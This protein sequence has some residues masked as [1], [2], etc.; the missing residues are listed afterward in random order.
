MTFD[1][2]LRTLHIKSYKKPKDGATRALLI[3]IAI[4]ASGTQEIKLKHNYGSQDSFQY[5]T[6]ILRRQHTTNNTINL[7]QSQWTQI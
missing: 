3:K 1:T 6:K 7:I 4:S 5:R 2:Y